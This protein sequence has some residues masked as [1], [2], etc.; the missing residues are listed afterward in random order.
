MKLK[1]RP[2]LKARDSPPPMLR[3]GEPGRRGSAVIPPPRR[4]TARAPDVAQLHRE[5]VRAPH[6]ARLEERVLV[7]R[8]PA[9]PRVVVQDLVEERVLVLVAV[10]AV[11][12]AAEREVVRHRR[13]VL[14]GARRHRRARRERAAARRE[15]GDVAAAREVA[16]AAARLFAEGLAQ[17]LDRPEHAEVGHAA[18]V[19]RA[20][21]DVHRRLERGLVPLEQPRRVRDLAVHVDVVGVVLD[22][23]L[24]ERLAA[25]QHERA[26]DVDDDRALVHHA[27]DVE[28][29][30]ERGLD[31]VDLPEQRVVR[32]DVSKHGLHLARRAARARECEALVLDVAFDVL[33]D[34][35]PRVPAHAVDDDVVLAVRA[36]QLRPHVHLHELA[37]LGLAQTLDLFV[38]QRLRALEERLRERVL[39]VLLRVE[40]VEEDPAHRVGIGL[41]E[42]DEL[43][44]RRRQL[45]RVQHR[46]RHHWA[47][48]FRTFIQ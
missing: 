42:V 27:L 2:Y 44:E 8:E 40:V 23:R 9:L 7:R 30:V 46:Q 29:V 38:V 1:S 32:E 20:R 3:F 6:D 21:H 19:R 18:S 26:C 5:H 24:D 4:R 15:R 45:R 12:A 37:H 31:H 16:A 11:H 33:E 36:R 25:R 22:A 41:G 10:A 39:D 35:P 13:A 48:R 34:E 43:I 17:P 47:A 14:L 28:H